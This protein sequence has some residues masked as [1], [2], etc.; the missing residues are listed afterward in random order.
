MELTVS[1]PSR[2]CSMLPSTC[3]DVS[4]V[5]DVHHVEGHRSTPIV[6]AE[7]TH[8]GDGK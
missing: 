4:N 5:V 6:L 1:V 7:G 8:Y 3:A 2:Y